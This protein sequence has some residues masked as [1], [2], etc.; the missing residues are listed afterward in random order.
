MTR[1]MCVK[2]VTTQH[3]DRGSVIYKEGEV[4]SCFNG[5]RLQG[6]DIFSLAIT[7]QRVIN[8]YRLNECLMEVE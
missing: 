5:N 2:T 1:Y 6:E 4:Y 8:K 7:E 3:T